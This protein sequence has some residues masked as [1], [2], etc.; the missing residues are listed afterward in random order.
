[1]DIQNTEINFCQEE[2]QRDAVLE[3]LLC[4]AAATAIVQLKRKKEHEEKKRGRRKER[5]FGSESG[6]CRE[7]TS[8]SMKTFATIT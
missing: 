3:E 6:Y 5:L 8:V 4:L 7:Q 2:A 1:M